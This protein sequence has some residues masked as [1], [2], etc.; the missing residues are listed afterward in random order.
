M[1]TR[2]PIEEPSNRWPWIVIGL[3][4][5]LVIVGVGAFMLNRQNAP[6]VSI[7]G[8][9]TA[10]AVAKASPPPTLAAPT[11]PASAPTTT[12]APQPTAAPS[13]TPL[14]A[15]TKPAAA[16]PPSPAAAAPTQASAPTTPAAPAAATPPPAAAANPT[17]FS[18]QVSNTGGTGN[19]RQDLDA[20]LGPPTGETPEHLVVY[21]KNNVEYHVD[22]APDLNGRSTLIVEVPPTPMALDAA[23]TEAKKL[24]PKDAQ[25][26]NPN[27]EGSDQFVV[28]RFT[29]DSL[30]QALGPDPFTAVQAQPGQLMALYVRD[31]TRGGQITRIIVGIGN[32][33]G[34]LLNRG[35]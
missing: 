23:M 1:A 11:L 27:P 3:V 4:V 30:A 21:R 9:P 14:P 6:N 25:P 8:T 28:Q 17:P 16:A 26:P 5:L 35:R 2:T 10:A 31:P 29:S 15:P 34:A 22:L 7:E 13:P 12:P 20:A 18:G 24:L 32:D 19:T 33:P